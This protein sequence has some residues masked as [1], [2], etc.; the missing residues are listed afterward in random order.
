MFSAAGIA[1]AFPSAFDYIRRFPR[2]GDR[3]VEGDALDNRCAVR[4][5]GFESPLSVLQEI[6]YQPSSPSP[7]GGRGVEKYKRVLKEIGLISTGRNQKS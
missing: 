5:R 3:V 6:A 1:L 2:R 7:R 4:V